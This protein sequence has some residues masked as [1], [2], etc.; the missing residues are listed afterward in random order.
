[1]T[2]SE[3]ITS[4]KISSAPVLETDRL[5]LRGFRREDLDAHAATLGNP[6]VTRYLT[7]EPF[8]REDSW[9]RLMMAVGQWPLLGYGYWAVVL[10]DSGRLVGQC[11]FADFE[12]AMEPDIS[13]E[14]EMGWIFDPSV[15]G[16]GIAFEACAAALDWA[17]SELDATSY[18][19]LIS[20]DNEPS[21]RLA[22]RL[23]FE[24][25]PDATYRDEQVALF[26]KAARRG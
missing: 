12:R 18:P 16:Q 25:L 22:S 14:P 11:G 6:A 23:G 8:S 5:T 3:A 7:D 19:A 13:G 1:M 9:R 4:R 24:R 2:A 20:V 26:R 17:D 10:K 21:I 15:H